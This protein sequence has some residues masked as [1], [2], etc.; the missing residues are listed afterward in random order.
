M[1]KFDKKSK[2]GGM[3]RGRGKEEGR[4][5]S[6]REKEWKRGGELKGARGKGSE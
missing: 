4:D 6:G 1:A 3:E 5:R 2:E